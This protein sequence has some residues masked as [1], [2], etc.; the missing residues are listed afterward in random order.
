MKI[1]YLLLLFAFIFTTGFVHAQKIKIKKKIVYIDGEKCLE[2]GGDANNVSFFDLDG[3]EIIFLKYIRDSRY[4]DL[5]TKVTFLDKK[6]SFT[7]KSYIFTKKLLIKKLLS[8][9]TLKDCQLN[10]DKVENFVLKFDENVEN[11]QIKVEVKVTN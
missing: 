6:I 7:S 9:R 11:E 2:I 4:A 8:D 3:N 10:Q 5:Y 1:K